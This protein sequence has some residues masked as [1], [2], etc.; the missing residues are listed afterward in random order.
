METLAVIVGLLCV[1]FIYLSF[2][3][4]QIHEKKDIKVF[5]KITK[6]KKPKK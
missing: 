5:K 6:T 4:V 1:V 2:K 3:H